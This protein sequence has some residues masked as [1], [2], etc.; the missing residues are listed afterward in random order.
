MLWYICSKFVSVLDVVLLPVYFLFYKNQPERRR[1]WSWLES[2][3]GSVGITTPLKS[4]IQV[5]EVESL[6]DSGPRTMADFFEF[7]VDKHSFKRCLGARSVISQVK[8]LGLNGNIVTKNVLGDYN[9]K[10]FVD[11]N[12]DSTQIGNGL[13]KLGLV[14]GD[15]ICIFAETRVE[16]MET[17]LACFK[18]NLPS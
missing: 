18:Y 13:N 2:L 11:V 6:L 4:K 12:N 5:P 15:K 14:A 8:E 16:W 10:S 9:W 3:P 1:E 7:C 17:A